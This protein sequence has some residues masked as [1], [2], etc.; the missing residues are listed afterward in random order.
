M[1]QWT[2]RYGP[3]YKMML[4]DSLAVVLTDPDAI[5]R[6]TSKTGAT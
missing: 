6:I 3:L 4:I 5:R 1:L 2:E